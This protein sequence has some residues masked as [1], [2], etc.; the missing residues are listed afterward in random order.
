ML[1]IAKNLWLIPALP[2]VAAGV[3]A[4]RNLNDYTF[5]A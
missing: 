3:L 1:W 5:A 4:A 2:L